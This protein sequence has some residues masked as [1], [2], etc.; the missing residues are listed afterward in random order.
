MKR[1]LLPL[2]N[3]DGHTIGC[4]T[5]GYCHGG[6]KPLHPVVHLHITDGAGHILLQ[7]RSLTK[8]IQPG[9]WDT[10]VGGHVDMGE[11]VIDAL[12]RECAEELGL[13]DFAPMPITTYEFESD[14]ERELVNVFAIRCTPG[15]L[16]L[17]PDPDEI[18]R[19]QWWSYDE[20]DAA[21]GTGTLTPNFEQEFN[22]IRHLL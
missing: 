16:V 1:E 8:D 13:R 19:V 15:T 2:V 17:T 21:T 11:P 7:K 22:L 3:S 4:A 10:A 6:A 20:I 9:R 14:R 18:D 5:R 12:T